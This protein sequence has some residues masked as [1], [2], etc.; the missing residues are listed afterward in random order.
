MKLQYA[1]LITLK[2][3]SK[4]SMMHIRTLDKILKKEMDLDEF[5]KMDGSL[6][7]IQ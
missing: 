3:H 2:L 5:M 7:L 4:A 1:I 6:L